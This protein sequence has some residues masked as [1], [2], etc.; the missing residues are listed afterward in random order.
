MRWQFWFLC[1]ILGLIATMLSVSRAK[2]WRFSLAMMLTLMTL[3]AILI[4]VVVIDCS[5]PWPPRK[6]GG[7]GRTLMSAPSNGR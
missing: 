2:G 5:R 7:A 6:L 1:V 3:V 4:G